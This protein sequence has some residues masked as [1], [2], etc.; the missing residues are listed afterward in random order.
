MLFRRYSFPNPEKIVDHIL[1]ML[2]A[3]NE[4]R[5]IVGR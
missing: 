1:P 2:R 5:T 3:N 4:F